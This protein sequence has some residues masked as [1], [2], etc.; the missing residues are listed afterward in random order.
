MEQ[1][2]QNLAA[3]FASGGTL[4]Q[5]ANKHKSWEKPLPKDG[6]NMWQIGK[7]ISEIDADMKRRSYRLSDGASLKQTL[8]QQQGQKL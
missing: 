7:S 4:E 2:Q 5:A 8:R 3:H 1:L 6:L